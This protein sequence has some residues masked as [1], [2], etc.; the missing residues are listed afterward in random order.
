MG[1]VCIVVKALFDS[2]GIEFITP[3]VNSKKT[4]EIGTKY[5]PELACLPLKINIGNF[6]ESIKL[7][8]DTIV[9][10]GGCGPCRFGYYGQVQREILKDLGLNAD[11][12]V[13]DKPDENLE[14]FLEKIRKLSGGNSYLKILSA[15]KDATKVSIKLDRLERISFYTRPREIKK[16]ETDNIL[17]NFYGRVHKTHGA[18][19]LLKLIYETEKRL[20]N[21]EIDKNLKPLKI[22]IVGEIYVVIEPFTNLRIEQML[23]N[24]GIEVLRSVTLSEWICDHMLKKALRIP[25]RFEYVKEAKPYLNSMIG[26]H[27]Q[28]TVGHCVMYAKQ[29]YDG[30]IQIYPFSCMPEIVA[31]SLMPAISRDFNIPIMTLV[32]DEMTGEAG[33]ATRIEAFVDMLNRRRERNKTGHEYVLSGN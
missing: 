24:M 11:F 29:G 14:D 1:N 21:I 19:E 9:N 20:K 10:A 25:Q 32:I 30:I 23:G 8:A 18:K 6:I 12:I 16:G 33:Y 3:P 31:E 26:G 2:L 15:I 27:A 4:L 7:G 5:A 28:E 17:K 22:A 13:L